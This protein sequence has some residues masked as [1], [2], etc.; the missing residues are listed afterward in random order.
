MEKKTEKILK[1]LE[2]K[3]QKNFEKNFEKILM[4]WIEKIVQKIGCFF[5]IRFK[6]ISYPIQ[7]VADVQNQQQK[8]TE[9]FTR[10]DDFTRVHDV[11]AVAS[12]G[13]LRDRELAQK[14][15]NF[16]SQ[17]QITIKKVRF[18]KIRWLFT[19][20]FQSTRSSWKDELTTFKWSTV[21]SPKRKCSAG[22]VALN[23]PFSFSI[24]SN[25]N[26]K[27]KLKNFQNPKNLF[28]M[29]P[30]L[31]KIVFKSFFDQEIFSEFFS[32]F[33]KKIKNFF[34]SKNPCLSFFKLLKKNFLNFFSH[35]VKKNIFR[36]KFFFIPFKTDRKHVSPL[37]R[38]VM[39]PKVLSVGFRRIRPHCMPEYFSPN[40]RH[41][42]LEKGKEIMQE[43]SST[44]TPPIP[45]SPP[46]PLQRRTYVGEL[47]QNNVDA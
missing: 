28:K 37:G 11:L 32:H 43:S 25:Y 47:L 19:D 45:P 18:N 35:F 5:M 34:W 4:E 41:L 33:L 8:V 44:K 39:Q 20:F 30:T 13:P 40:L 46:P 36:S 23:C 17:L 21:N 3:L 42:C 12:D 6:L 2:K 22:F 15:H 38:W 1:N 9:R 26:H 29:F 10:L 7:F 16:Q 14:Q 27:T 31:L 24:W